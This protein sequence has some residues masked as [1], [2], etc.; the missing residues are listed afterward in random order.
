MRIRNVDSLTQGAFGGCPR[1]TEGCFAMLP[2]N[3]FLAR[4][5][6]WHRRQR[7]DVGGV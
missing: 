7:G 5:G 4:P 2:F 6:S 1:A 3:A